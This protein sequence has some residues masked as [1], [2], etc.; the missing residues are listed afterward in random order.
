MRIDGRFY[1]SLADDEKEAYNIDHLSLAEQK[2]LVFDRTING[3][4][5]TKDA[6]KWILNWNGK[7]KGVWSLNP[8]DLDSLD[9]DY[10]LLKSI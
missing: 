6:N 5:L 9:L 2:K 10:W 7:K 8:S 3:R 1:N 4:H